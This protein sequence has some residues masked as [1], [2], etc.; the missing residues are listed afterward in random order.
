MSAGKPCNANFVMDLIP[1]QSGN[2]DVHFTWLKYI[3]GPGEGSLID[4]MVGMK[5]PG[6]DTVMFSNTDDAQTWLLAWLVALILLAA[7]AIARLGLTKA[8]TAGGTLQYVP[9]AQMSVRNVFE[10]FTSA[11]FGLVSDLL[12]HENGK[13]FFWISAGLFIYILTSNLL[14]I[15][16]GMLPPSGSLQHNLA[17]SLVVLVLFNGAGIK[18]QGLVGYLKHM[19]GPVA[20]LGVLLF[21]IELLSFLVVRPYSLSLRLTGNMFGDHQVLSIMS[22]LVPL[23][24]PII[25]L[26][27]GI[28][29]SLIQRFVFTLL[30]TIY[31][32]L[33]VEH[34]DH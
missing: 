15:L 25:F 32:A 9:D 23:G 27:L 2:C 29:V 28:F 21:G 12:G 30:S 17:I 1:A 18:A 11:L 19:C 5:M 26:G 13:K 4:A 34:D 33:A 24:Y 14:G 22:G 10:L 6:T 8:L 3:P 16:P 31:I 20:A 7:S